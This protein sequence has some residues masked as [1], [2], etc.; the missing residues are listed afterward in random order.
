M[1]PG[2][3][4]WGPDQVMDTENLVDWDKVMKMWV[5]VTRDSA[6]D[7]PRRYE[8]IRSGCY[9]TTP[10]EWKEV[11]AFYQIDGSDRYPVDHTVIYNGQIQDYQYVR[12]A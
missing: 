9:K 11:W 8:I 3:G 1:E 4:L 7:G 10:Q 5:E 2:D 6:L 12:P